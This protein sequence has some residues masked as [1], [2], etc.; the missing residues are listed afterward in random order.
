MI[1]P[2]SFTKD[3]ILKQR[4]AFPQ[5]DPQLIER[6]IYAFELVGLLAG[7]K[8]QFVFKGGTALLLLL[9]TAHRLSID[10]DIVG[11]FDLP[12]LEPIIFGSVF[13]RVEEDER[14]KDE[15][16]K[17]HFKFFYTSAID[18][19][20]T[21]VLLDV[22]YTKHGYSQ[23]VSLPIKNA[24]FSVSN[25]TLVK[26]PTVDG[27]LG[28]KL[29][30]FA[31]NTTG[32]PFGKKKSMEIIKQLFDIGELFNE[33]KDIKQIIANYRSIQKQESKYHTSAPTITESLEDTIEIS[34]LFCQSRLKGCK[35]NTGVEEIHRGLKQIYSYLLGVPFHI[36][37]ARV[38]ASKAALLATLIKG[39][40]KDYD[41][42]GIKY[43]PAR[44]EEIR[45]VSLKGNLQI[46]NKLKETQTESFYYWWLISQIK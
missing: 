11:D 19:K 14:E 5:A 9:Q 33:A 17:K 18:N 46:L 38:S 25:E 7:T 8:K 6:Q 22:L 39:E 41:I 32:V 42:S 2:K 13:R 29:T 27:I 15:I 37:Q 40:K 31:P 20:E 34:Y 23:L 24:I 26:T 4:K 3:W 36:E 16:P 44:V 12:D 30:A 28:D 10:I 1:D 43:N 45:D 35:E 21:Y